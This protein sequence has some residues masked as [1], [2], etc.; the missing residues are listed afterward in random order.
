MR[1]A[2]AQI[3]NYRNLDGTE[4]V[5]DPEVNF[6]VGENDLGK[7]NLLDLFE[8]LFFRRYFLE[9]DFED[10]AKPI[11]VEFTLRLTDIEK[12]IFD[13]HF[14]SADNA[15]IS[16]RA[17]QEI[18]DSDGRASF[19]WT[20]S[21]E[22]SSPE[23]AIS[24]SQLRT[25]NY[26][27]YDSQKARKEELSFHKG[28]GGGR[29]LGY[30]VNEFVGNT[31][32]ELDIS[33]LNPAVE[34]IKSVL[35]RL[36]P[37]KRQ[38]LG[39][40]TGDEDPIEFAARTLLLTGADGLDIHRS[41]YGVQFSTL[42][43]FAILERL[44]QQKQ[45]ARFR[46]FEEVRNFFTWAEYKVFS[47]M[48]LKDDAVEQILR[49]ITHDTLEGYWVTLD[50]LDA[51]SRNKLPPDLVKHVKRRKYVSMVLGLDEPEIHLHP[52]MQRSLLKYIRRLINNEDDDFLFLLK[53]FFDIDA[54]DGQLL[55]VTHSPAALFDRHQ[56]IV[57]FHRDEKLEI[58][59]GNTISLEP[60]TQ[61]Q[62]FL[63]FPY[64]SEAFFSRCVIVVEG[65][66]ELGALPLWASKTIG[67]LDTYGI[68]VLRGVGGKENIPPVV[69]LLSHFRIP[70]VSIID[71]DDNNHQ[72]PRFTSIAHLR[73]TQHRDFEEE[74]L[75]AIRKQDPDFLALQ[76]LIASY[77]EQGLEKSIQASKLKKV[78]KTYNIAESW[79]A[80]GKLFSFR[81][82]LAEGNEDLI[83]AMFL[84]WLG[85]QKNVV[86]GRLLGDAISE[87]LIP[88]TYLDLF[89]DA[90][91]I[92]A[93]A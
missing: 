66:T 44:V 26:I 72:N 61:K 86:F 9:E 35:D 70:N 58:T 93:A 52:Y 71:K 43:I 14:D 1:I 30:L 15:L 36:L 23:I 2:R 20:G 92:V 60:H 88:Q 67:D 53:R 68:T 48:W 54:I 39:L 75:E 90:K 64:I 19:F 32:L 77:E 11:E 79:D 17:R 6:L 22:S 24:T 42:L 91:K 46:A 16:L 87:E 80:K 41:G 38:G 49:P 29:F 10:P 81:D 5:F 47:E 65:D 4:F 37:L 21:K 59:S 78:A 85:S 73:T 56:Q 83:K 69:E 76:D 33:A 3:S 34:G 50:K 62:L 18:A 8:A 7:S 63:N 84:A 31:D 28:R 55:V 74:L 13:D 82:T 27:H 25:L 45:Y 51:E 40:H 57:R 12:G 89:E